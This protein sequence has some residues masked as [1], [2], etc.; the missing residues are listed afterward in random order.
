MSEK[1]GRLPLTSK[2][3][4]VPF[5]MIIAVSCKKSDIK[6]DQK[7]DEIIN[8]SGR[9]ACDVK[10]TNWAMNTGVQDTT[11]Q[12]LV[13]V[14]QNDNT[15]FILSHSFPLD[16]L[17]NGREYTKGYNGSNYVRVQFINDS[18]HYFSSSGGLGGGS[19]LKYDGIRID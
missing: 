1:R 5:L 9:Y 13:V 4:S 17:A 8:Y 14:E 12:Q 19:R 6:G 18:L 15:V 7:S 16:S 3:V 2:Y 10:R 11:Y